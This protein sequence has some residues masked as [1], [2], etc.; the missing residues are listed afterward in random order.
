MRLLSMTKAVCSTS[1][2]LG[3]TV[4][5]RRRNAYDVARKGSLG[6]ADLTQIPGITAAMRDA[7]IAWRNHTTST[8]SYMGRDLQLI[9]DQRPELSPISGQWRF[10]WPVSKHLSG[11]F[12]SSFR[13][14]TCWPTRRLWACPRKAWLTWVP[15]VARSMHRPGLR[16]IRLVPFLVRP[17]SRLR[18]CCC[19]Y[20][21]PPPRRQ[22]PTP[23]AARLFRWRTVTSS[24]CAGRK[25]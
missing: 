23:R 10:E 25:M 14:R 3:T 17:T 21:T 8:S 24:T 16:S 13:V 6:L 19:R 12:K 2:R 20:L 5:C 15:S 9:S 7:L 1:I 4:R 18:R 22:I 11:R